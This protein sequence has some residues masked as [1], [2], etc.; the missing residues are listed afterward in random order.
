MDIEKYNF[1]DTKR[2]KY[3][4]FIKSITLIVLICLLSACQNI[5]PE[6]EKALTLSGSNKKELQKV[7][8]YYQE[9]KDS[10]KLKAAYFLIKNMSNKYSIVGEGLEKLNTIF[11]AIEKARKQN[12]VERDPNSDK[13]LII[14][15]LWN[16]LSMKNGKL[17]HFSLSIKQD[18]NTIKSDFLIENIEYSFKAWNFPWSRHLSFEEF[19][20]YILPYRVSEESLESWRPAVYDKYK[21]LMD[22]LKASN[23]KDPV[24]VCK[25]INKQI[26]SK[27]IYSPTLMKYPVAMTADN[28]MKGYMGS[29]KH[30]VALA[31]FTM[32]ALGI[33]VV[34]EQV[35]HYGN[36]SLGHDFNGVLS[37]NGNFIDFEA[38]D[39]KRFGKILDSQKEQER[40]IP[41]IYRSTYSLSNKSLIALKPKNEIIPIFFTNQSITDVTSQYL[42]VSSIKIKLTTQVPANCSYVYLCVFDNKNWQAVGW[43]KI[44]KNEVIF[45]NMGTGI[46]YMPMYYVNSK[47]VT[48]SSSLILDRTGTTHNIISVEK[49][50][51]MVLKRKYKPHRQMQSQMINTTFEVSNNADFKK[52]TNLYSIKDSV[53]L[54]Q[55]NVL[56]KNHR[57]YRYVRYLVSATKRGDISEMSFLSKKGT[58]LFGKIITSKNTSRFVLKNNK[59][60]KNTTIKNAFDS[61]VLSFAVI[62]EDSTE[63]WIG[64]DFGIKKHIS[65]LSFCPRTDKNDVWPEL[66]YELFYWDKGWKSIGLKKAST[67]TLIYKSP[68]SNAL[69]LLRCLDEGEEERI[70]TYRNGKQ[71]WW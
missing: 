50:Q 61:D 43:S 11:P 67:N 63:Q 47:L 38:G 35:P 23:L 20:E 15:S 19:C 64:L 65:K 30:Q 16:N 10:L 51:E 1:K 8:E 46:L 42:P 54:I 7:I 62:L 6:V 59:N 55:Q 71:I 31:T 12:I 28:L 39:N 25:I 69:F 53:E 14:D 17:I 60:V 33:P 21:P 49:E 3:V 40:Y 34:C 26:L 5:P 9:P 48:A 24:K 32:R 66:N 68:V 27:W 58:P 18:L 57:K 22:S 29:C 41:K 4:A 52:T 70:F 13:Y 36:R 37:K 2:M 44:I 45:T 56:I